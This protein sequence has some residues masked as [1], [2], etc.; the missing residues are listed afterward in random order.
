[1]R[2]TKFLPTWQGSKAS[3]VKKLQHHYGKDFVELFCGSCVIS[4]SLAKTA[5]LNDI[6]PFIYKIMKYFDEQIVPDIFTKKEYLDIR[7]TEDWWKYSFCLM[8]LAHNSIF[9]YSKNGFNIVPKDNVREFDFRK[10]YKKSLLIWKKLSPTVF[11]L[12]YNE[13]PKELLYNKVVISDPPYENANAAYNNTFDY[14]EYWEFIRN[15]ESKCE[16]VIFDF[17]EN[18]PFICN[19]K[20]SL[21]PIGKYKKNKEGMFEFRKSKFPGYQGEKIF[22]ELFPH[23]RKLD[24]NLFEYNDKKILL[25]SDYYNS[26]RTDNFIID[27]NIFGDVD[28][29]VYFYC[30]DNKIFIFEKDSFIEKLDKNKNSLTSKYISRKIF[31]DIEISKDWLNIESKNTNKMNVNLSEFLY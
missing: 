22:H 16:L 2:V 5:I 6:D 8:K 20:K 9:R 7:F 24:N 25:R 1:M 19:G 4:A 23:L 27:T 10:E 31:N 12:S 15:L 11:N 21:L 3:W 29:Y 13:I 26:T 18:I 17:I 30:G 14:H 28:L